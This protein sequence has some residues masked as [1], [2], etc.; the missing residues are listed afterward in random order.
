MAPDSAR[1]IGDEEPGA[2]MVMTGDF[3]RGCT[4]FS[5]GGASLSGRRLKVLSSYLRL[6]S[7]SNQ[8]IRW[9]RDCSSLGNVSFRVAQRRQTTY[10]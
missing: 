2:S 4:F 3:P 9:L 5:S 6:S 8:R 10:Q 1:T 7:S